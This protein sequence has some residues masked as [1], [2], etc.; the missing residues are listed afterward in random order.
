MA[1]S[2]L[3]PHEVIHTIATYGMEQEQGLSDTTN[4]S[5]SCGV[6]WLVQ[7]A[8]LAWF[9]KALTLPVSISHAGRPQR[10]SH[11]GVLASLPGAST[12]D[13]TPHAK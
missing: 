10:A 3:L 8:T 12:M 11:G 2:V 9:F 5:K 13:I 4:T 7:I 1:V 6:L